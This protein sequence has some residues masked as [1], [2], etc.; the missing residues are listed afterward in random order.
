MFETKIL[1][2]ERELPTHWYNIA[3]D[4]PQPLQPPL[5]PDTREPIDPGDL[6]PIF[7]RSLIEQEISQERW[8]EIPEEV[9]EVLRLWRPTPLY[10]A[11]RLEK[12]LDTPAKI[13][14]KYEGVSPA[15]SHK[16]NT[17]VAQAYYNKVEGI[18]RLATE[19]GAGQW[20]SALSFACHLFG[21]ECHVYMVRISYEQKPYRRSMM[22]V[23][24]AQVTPSPSPATQA[25][26]E[27]LERDPDCQGSLGIA[28]G[29]AIEDTLSRA[30]TKYALGSV[31]N[32]VLLHQTV[33]GMEVKKQLEKAGDIPDIVI[34]CCGGGSNFAGLGFPFL[35]DKIHGQKMRVIAVEPAA[36]PTLT[37][38]EF[39][40][41]FGDTARQTP[42][43]PMY[44][45]GHDFIPPGIH[46]GG[47]R[48][49]GMAPLVSQVLADGLI[50]ARSYEQQA[51]FEASLLFARTEGIIAAPEAAHAIRATIDEAIQAREEGTERVLLFALTGH[52]YFDMGAFAAYLKGDLGS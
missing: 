4:L 48:Y 50:E 22:E 36:C 19:T 6:A 39:T 29:E 42:L 15:G 9:R 7:P 26:R 1:L 20:G 46:A 17:A 3:A 14:Y 13:Y 51:C 32:H 37:Q 27:I 2:K 31:L 8:I 28:I 44:T 16:P 41:D 11:H 5:N 52:G 38:G 47:L 12:H 23:W 35:R 30:D 45:L 43:L 10:R 49:H 25:G 21:L 18:K 24:G 33:I 34:G 40:Y